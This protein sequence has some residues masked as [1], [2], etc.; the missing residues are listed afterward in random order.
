[1]QLGLIHR[2]FPDAK[3]IFATRDPRDVILSAFQQHFEQNYA[4]F[5]F[6]NFDSAAAYYDLIMSFGAMMREKSAN[7]F[8]DVRYEDVVADLEGEARR[9]TAFL[10]VPWNEAML[11]YDETAKRR[12]V[13]T[14]SA[15]QVIQRPYSTSIGKWKNYRDEM[16]PVM[17]V[18]APWVQRFG[19]DND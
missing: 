8:H 16:A 3:I 17:P 15:T 6:L 4:M 1:M 9:L 12:A 5:Q 13:R 14:A 7:T 19:Y 11:A 18:L 2:L 10:G